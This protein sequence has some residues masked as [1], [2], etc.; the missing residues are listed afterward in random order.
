M[1]NVGVN[2]G[3]SGLTV[4]VDVGTTV[5]PTEDLV[6]KPEDSVNPVTE[7]LAG[8][9]TRDFMVVNPD[10]S[11]VTN[12]V[13]AGSWDASV[14]IEGNAVTISLGVVVITFGK[15]VLNPSEIVKLVVVTLS[16]DVVL[17]ASFIS[18]EEVNFVVASRSGSLDSDDCDDME[19]DGMGVFV[20]GRVVTSTVVE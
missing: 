6:E 20:G 16:A 11:L 7:I 9:L 4:S 17:L 10:R 18:G 2:P 14:V 13:R 12:V 1:E 15:T 5:V 3:S 8:D 19:L